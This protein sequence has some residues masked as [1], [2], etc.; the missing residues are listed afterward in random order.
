VTAIVKTGRVLAAIATLFSVGFAIGKINKNKMSCMV[1][2]KQ[3]G[4]TSKQYANR[5]VE[6]FYEDLDEAVSEYCQYLDMGFNP[7]D[8]FEIAKARS[9]L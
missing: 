5:L 9:I 4:A 1:E 2:S 7:S 8:A 3:L 6:F